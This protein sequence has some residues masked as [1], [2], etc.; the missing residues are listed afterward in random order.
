MTIGNTNI[1]RL[2]L[3]P[4]CITFFMAWHLAVQA[5]LKATTFPSNFRNTLP[6]EIVGSENLA[7]I[8]TK[9]KQGKTV[10]V[11]QIG[12]SHVRGNI[13]PNTVGSTLKG[14]FPTL[15]FCHYGINGAW[16]KRFYEQDMITRVATEHPDL[17]IIS[18]GTNEAHGSIL[19]ETSH[20][21]SMSLLTQRIKEACPNT[22]FLFTTPP[23]SFISKRTT[24]RRRRG[25]RRSYVSS[26]T[27]NLN[28]GRVANSIVKFCNNN[29]MAVWDIYN[30]GGGDRSACTNWLNSGEMN[31]DA[32]H[33][34]ASGYTRQ[35]QL[36]GEAIYKAYSNLE[37]PSSTFS[38]PHE[39]TPADQTPHHSIEENE[40]FI[41]TTR[42]TVAHYDKQDDNN[43][44]DKLLNA[45]PFTK[46]RQD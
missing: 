40:E 36:L 34:L 29:H 44:F 14:F 38:L 24:T 6:N 17:V 35:G 1:Q 28:N 39:K 45:L 41:S 22:Q 7:M 5:Q 46:K 2:V 32:I 37:I 16:A 27:P 18:F 21:Q 4:L 3:V 31:S 11:M 13:F 42:M 15:Q 8:F 20:A 43:I 33:Y 30:I 12:D 9:V 19:D 25:R 23:G 26:R 10:K